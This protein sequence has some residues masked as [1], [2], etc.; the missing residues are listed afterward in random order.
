MVADVRRKLC[1]Q[2]L[3]STIEGITVAAGYHTTIA[4][5]RRIW[6]TRVKPDA[7]PRPWVGLLVDEATSE[8]EG[9]HNELVTLV[10]WLIAIAD[11]AI[12][13]VTAAALSGTALEDALDDELEEVANNLEADLRKAIRVDRSRDNNAANTKITS[14]TTNEGDPQVPGERVAIVKMRVEIDY[15]RTTNEDT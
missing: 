13:D 12:D 9:A 5:V 2:D 8:E 14:S 10:V 1:L 7:A 3:R 6:A 15:E 11:C 4:R